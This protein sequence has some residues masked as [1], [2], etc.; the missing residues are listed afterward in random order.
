MKTNKFFFAAITLFFLGNA[1]FCQ[2]QKINFWKGGTP[3]QETNWNCA[4]NWSPNKVPDG[5][6]NVIIPDVSTGSGVYPTIMSSGLEVNALTLES[7]ATLKIEKQASLIIH[8]TFDQ[9]GQS[10]MELKGALSLPSQ[11]IAGVGRFDEKGL[12][13]MN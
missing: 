10:E 2:A 5:F 12:W 9:W 4:K 3:G 8:T 11:T 1:T 6:Q 7:G 13:V